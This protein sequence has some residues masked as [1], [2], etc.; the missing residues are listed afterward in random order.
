[1]AGRV[2]AGDPEQ[3][4]RQAL[5]HD[6]PGVEQ[7]RHALELVLVADEE[8]DPPRVRLPFVRGGE[9]VRA[10]AD[11]DHDRW[12]AAVVVDDRVADPAAHAEDDACLAERRLLELAPAL[13]GVRPE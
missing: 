8:R 12:V 5:A 4:L 3:R 10:G 7:R 1:P 13:L 2:Y 11:R 6:L 9:R